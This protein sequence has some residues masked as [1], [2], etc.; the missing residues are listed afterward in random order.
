MEFTPELIKSSEQFNNIY[1]NFIFNIPRIL[2]ESS[3]SDNLITQISSFFIDLAVI[4]GA[5]ISY[6][7]QADKFQREQSS[8]HQ[9]QCLRE[10]CRVFLHLLK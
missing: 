1:T 8:R 4:F 2:S 9:V 5:S 10:V 7:F 6:F 3:Q